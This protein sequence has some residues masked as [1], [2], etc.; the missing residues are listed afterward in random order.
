MQLSV[1]NLQALVSIAEQLTNIAATSVPLDADGTRFKTL[2]NPDEIQNIKDIAID[3]INL[4][5]QPQRTPKPK[6][7]K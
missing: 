1:K 2:Y 5:L 4:G 6:I 3:L 7:K